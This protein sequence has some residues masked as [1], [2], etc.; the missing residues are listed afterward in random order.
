V[1]EG[2]MAARE[3]SARADS[4]ERSFQ[5]YALEKSLR[6]PVGRIFSRRVRPSASVS[7]D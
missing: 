3:G 5:F 6:K 7:H 2:D 1:E 4:V